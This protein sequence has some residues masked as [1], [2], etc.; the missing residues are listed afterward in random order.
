M[1]LFSDYKLEREDKHVLELEHGFAVYSFGDDF[2]YLEDIYVRPEIR[3]SGLGS[4]MADQISNLA[5]ERGLKR[6]FGSVSTSGKNAHENLLALLAYGFRLHKSTQD[7]I[8]FVK[9][10]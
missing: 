8:Y 9:D 6:L 3:R 1:S 10:L 5:R 2:C 4:K 7:L